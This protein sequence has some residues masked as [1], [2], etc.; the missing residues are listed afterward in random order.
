[1][2]Q[3]SIPSIPNFDIW[4]TASLPPEVGKLEIF[5]YP[6][7]PEHPGQFEDEAGFRY[8]D[9]SRKVKQLA[10]AIADGATEAILSDVWA[11]ALVKSFVKRPPSKKYGLRPEWWSD[12]RAEFREDL[13]VSQ[14][15]WY[16][17]EKLA[18]GSFATFGGVTLYWPDRQFSVA[19]F[20]DVVIA[21][22]TSQGEVSIYP[23][24]FQEASDF[25]NRPTLV[26]TLSSPQDSGSLQNRKTL[27]HS[28]CSI[29]LMTDAIGAWFVG[30]LSKS[31][32]AAIEQIDA[33]S[34]SNFTEFVQNARSS[35][36]MRTD[37]VA[38]IRLHLT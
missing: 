20:G 15:P 23:N 32:A 4:Q 12:A 9:R 29:Y 21:L 18:N 22:V 16:A 19:G 10:L 30:E 33:L 6:K 11:K 14:L 5:R 35:K 25:S 3:E 37:D 8:F 28:S 31:Q 7:D 27:P 17:L 36:S 26:G 2:S 24:S 34:A 1:M 13:D 38:L